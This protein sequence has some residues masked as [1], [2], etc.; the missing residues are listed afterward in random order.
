MTAI[1]DIIQKL[2]AVFG[3][4][5]TLITAI[6]SVAIAAITAYNL[7]RKKLAELE[8]K[9]IAAPLS[10]IAETK[11]ETVL[12]N[13]LQKPQQLDPELQPVSKADI[14]SNEGK[15]AIVAQAA[16]ETI[17]IQK[18]NLLKKLGIKS[19]TDAIP[20]VSS[21]YQFAIKPVIKGLKK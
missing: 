19:A 18:P 10:T 21:L 2:I 14:E 13:L 15:A 7:I 6:V 9:Q 3:N 4:I 12:M 1:N 8:F 17:Q 11:P 20:L 5:E 16:I